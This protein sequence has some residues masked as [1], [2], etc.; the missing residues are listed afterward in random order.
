VDDDDT[1]STEA[2]PGLRAHVCEFGIV[3][4]PDH[5]GDVIEVTDSD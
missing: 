3:F 2:G 5:V 4:L 1:T